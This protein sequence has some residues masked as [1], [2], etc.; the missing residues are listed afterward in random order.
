[1]SLHFHLD[2]LER[3]K[4]EGED[5]RK[6]CEKNC[7][8]FLSHRKLSPKL[9]F[10]ILS[11]SFFSFLPSFHPLHLSYHQEGGKKKKIGDSFFFI[12]FS[13]FKFFLSCFFPEIDSVKNKYLSSSLSLPTLEESYLR[14]RRRRLSSL[15]IFLSLNDELQEGEALQGEKEAW[16][17]DEGERGGGKKAPTFSLLE[18]QKKGGKEENLSF[19]N[20]DTWSSKDW[21]FSL[22]PSSLKNRLLFLFTFFLSLITEKYF[23]YLK[24]RNSILLSSCNLSPFFLFFLTFFFFFLPFINGE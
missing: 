12:S 8:D 9:I 2:T 11:F 21:N 6:I 19:P 1:M 5:W 10:L 20:L 23:I 15:F 18:P 3:I 13:S 7:R 16:K 24:R 22:F 14:R 4:E 17:K